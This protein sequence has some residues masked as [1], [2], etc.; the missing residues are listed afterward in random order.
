MP[1]GPTWRLVL[2]T[3]S[4]ITKNSSE[5]FLPRNKQCS[6]RTCL[7][8][9]AEFHWLIKNNNNL[10]RLHLITDLEKGK[11]IFQHLWCSVEHP[12][13]LFIYSFIWILDVNHNP[14]L[15]PT[16]GL[17]PVILVATE[18]EKNICQ[19]K[20]NVIYRDKAAEV[21]ILNSIRPLCE[22][23]LWKH[24]ELGFQH[25]RNTILV[26]YCV[27]STPSLCRL[28]SQRTKWLS[29]IA[30]QHLMSLQ[31]RGLKG[32]NFI[33]RLY[34]TTQPQ[35]FVTCNFLSELPLKK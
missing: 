16:T 12:L 5:R 19:I 8:T 22:L 35:H 28:S 20:N 21:L 1:L 26:D 27:T 2:E 23:S 11:N 4:F 29:L 31:T 3:F 15:G 30:V 13:Y 9:E 17:N 6:C 10:F 14:G 18:R 32:C 24:V 7:P 34:E 33:V 25:R